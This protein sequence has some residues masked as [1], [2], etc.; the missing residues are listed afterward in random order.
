MVLVLRVFPV[1]V[2]STVGGRLT[3]FAFDTNSGALLAAQ[4]TKIPLIHNIEERGQFIAV[5]IV[6][7]HAVGDCH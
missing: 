3:G 5:L 4:I 6:A 1:S 7:V 2:D